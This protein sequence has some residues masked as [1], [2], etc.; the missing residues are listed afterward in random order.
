M[1]DLEVYVVRC[2]SYVAVDFTGLGLQALKAIDR[3]ED[4]A[5]CFF[6]HMK[7]PFG[8]APREASHDSYCLQCNPRVILDNSIDAMIG[9]ILSSALLYGS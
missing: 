4:L 1:G 5:S 2:T 7:I 8:S 6:R 3:I 9:M